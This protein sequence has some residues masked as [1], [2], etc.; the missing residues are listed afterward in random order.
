M[1]AKLAFLAFVFSLMGGTVAAQ[2]DPKKPD[3]KKLVTKVYNVKPLLGDRGKADTDAVI[4]LIFEA[5]PQLRELKPGTEG[6]QIVERDNGRL[7]IRTTEKRH[8]EVKDLLDALERLQ[9]LAIDVKADVIELDTATYEK[10]VKALPKQGTG[11]PPVLYATGEEIEGDEAPAIQ[12]ALDETNKILKTGRVIQT[13]NG[14]FVNGAEATVSARRR[15]ATFTNVSN[16]VRLAEKADNPL[17]V[18]EGFTLGMLPVVSGDRRFVRFK[19]TEQSTVI[20]G[21]KTRDFGEIAGEKFVV[22]T[23]ETEDLGATGS[24]TVAD[25][26]TLLFRLA[27]APKNKVWVVVLKPRIFIQAEEDE[28]KKEGKK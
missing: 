14:R 23:L 8:G 7:E 27:Y 3:D 22:K 10:L 26:G 15:L 12:K 5:I 19:L 4:K 6:P 17:F 11:K 9:D 25:G 21:V 13:S 20:T 18:K 2:P 28:L 1:S 24:A 16:P